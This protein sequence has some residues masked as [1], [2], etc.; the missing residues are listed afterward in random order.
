MKVSLKAGFG[1]NFIL[2]QEVANFTL[3]NKDRFFFFFLPSS[4]LLLS[5]ECKRGY[6]MAQKRQGLIYPAPLFVF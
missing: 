3:E 2:R 4:S 5:L 1:G 6:S